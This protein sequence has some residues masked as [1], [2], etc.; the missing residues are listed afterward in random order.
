MLDIKKI[1]LCLSVITSQLKNGVQI[2]GSLYRDLL[3]GVA[4]RDVPCDERKRKVW[5]GINK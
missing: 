2:W 3:R 4:F 1:F 5:L